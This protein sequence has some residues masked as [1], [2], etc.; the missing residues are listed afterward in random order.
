[1]LK[2]DDELVQGLKEEWGQEIHDAVVEALNEL[3]EYNPS[4]CYVVPELWNFAENRKAELDEAVSC[5]LESVKGTLKS[6]VID[7]KWVN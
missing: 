6:L 1:M 4:G 7:L 5:I 2:E 3:H